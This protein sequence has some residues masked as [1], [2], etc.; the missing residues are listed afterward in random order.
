[1]SQKYNE[2]QYIFKEIFYRNINLQTA[3]KSI[4]HTNPTQE[5]IDVVY[6]KAVELRNEAKL[7]YP[8]ATSV[9][10]E[11]L[12]ALRRVYLSADFVI[13]FIDESIENDVSYIKMHQ[14]L[15]GAIYNGI[16]ISDEVFFNETSKIRKKK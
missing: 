15:L 9:S 5:Q 14:E 13:K 11:F 1:M 8:Q 4:D 2:A 12:E 16:A 3:L 10:I 7:F 6:D